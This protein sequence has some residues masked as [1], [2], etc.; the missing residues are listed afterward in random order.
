MTLQVRWQLGATDTAAWAALTR[1]VTEH[2]GRGCNL[3]S[4]TQQDQ[5]SDKDM[6][7]RMKDT[8]RHQA[9]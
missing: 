6:M 7:P 1:G 9:A 5:V 2:T 8:G 4:N 3:A